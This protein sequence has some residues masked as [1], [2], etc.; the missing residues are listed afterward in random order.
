MLKTN[1]GHLISVIKNKIPYNAK[2][3]FCRFLIKPLP[4]YFIQH[5]TLIMACHLSINIQCHCVILK[6]SPLETQNDRLQQLMVF[7]LILN[8]RWMQ[9]WDRHVECR[10]LSNL[11]GKKECTL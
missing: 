6:L 11:Q 3:Y 2:Q 7:T 4:I 8:A 1:N 5:K 9:E 10:K